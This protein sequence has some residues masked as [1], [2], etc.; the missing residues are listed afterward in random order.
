MGDLTLPCPTADEIGGN[1]IWHFLHT[2]GVPWCDSYRALRKKCGVTHIACYDE[3]MIVMPAT[4]PV[5]RDLFMPLGF[6]RSDAHHPDLPVLH[7]SGCH[8]RTAVPAVNFFDLKHALDPFLGDGMDASVSNTASW[9]WRDGAAAVSLTIWPPELNTEYGPN[10]FHEREPR[11]ATACTLSISTGLHMPLTDAERSGL[12]DM[13]PVLAKDPGAVVTAER[14]GRLE[15]I[16]QYELPYARRHA[17]DFGLPETHICLT[18][19]R[20]MLVAGSAQVLL[21]LPVADITGIYVNR[22]L[23]ARSSGYASLGVTLR[24][25]VRWCPRKSFTLAT[26]PE[27]DDFNT[28]AATLATLLGVPLELGAYSNDV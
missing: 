20:R 10:S 14:C 15:D 3:L 13:Q 9:Q 26:R 18:A 5:V 27:A 12:A 25:G 28:D 21:L 22:I 19:D 4:L 7:V 17:G 16:R 8:F 2:A 24:T 11:L 6:A 1:R 23:P